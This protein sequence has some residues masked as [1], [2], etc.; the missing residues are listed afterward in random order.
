M[1]DK[2]IVLVA[3]AH[4]QNAVKTLRLNIAK[5]MNAVN[6]VDR[7][8]EVL[9]QDV[10]DSLDGIHQEAGRGSLLNAGKKQANGEGPLG[11]QALGAVIGDVVHFFGDFFYFV[12]GDLLDQRAAVQR[13]GN[14]CM[15]DAR[16]TCNVFDGDHNISPE[17]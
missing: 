17:K 8:V 9:I 15:G 1:I 7:Q 13:P 5:V 4:D 3:L 14:S 10:A 16:D 6:T 12:P 11:H 2:G